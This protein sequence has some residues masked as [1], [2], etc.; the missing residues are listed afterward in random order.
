MP[1][2]RLRHPYL[3][4][5]GGIVLAIGFGALIVRS[6]SA[7][8]HPDGTDV[9]FLTRI[10]AVMALLASFGVLF[11]TLVFC[12]LKRSRNSAVVWLVISVAFAASILVSLGE[13]RRIRHDAF[14][15][16]AER[17]SSLVE[18]IE[19]YD[20]RFGKPP[21][22]LGE[23]VPDFISVIPSTGMGAYPEYKYLAGELYE[24][25]PWVLIIH[26]PTAIGD[27]D[28][29]VYYPLQN[30]PAHWFGNRMERIRDWAYIHE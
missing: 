12:L 6:E 7:A 15:E 11:V 26:T 30:Y 9:H 27:F 17:S 21:E 16:L 3:A 23:L 19:R 22:K 1:I 10:L 28:Q 5:L 4:M 14:Y 18:A 2:T 8:L 20:N 25:N 13:A 29:F 24:G